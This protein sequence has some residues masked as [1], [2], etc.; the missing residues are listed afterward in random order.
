VRADDLVIPPARC[1][2]PPVVALPIRVAAVNG[3]ELVVEGVAGLLRR[4]PDRLEVCERIVIG[5]ELEVPVDVALYDT[6]GRTELVS[7]ALRTLI[8]QPFV[9]CVAI[10]TLDLSRPL[11]ADARGAGARGFISKA[12]SGDEVADALVRIADGEI[13]ELFHGSP[14]PATDVL[15][16]PGKND[17]LSERE[18]QVLVLCAQGLTNPEIAKSLYVG[19]ETVKSHLRNV[20]AKLGLKNRIEA[21][22]Y[23]L[24]AGGFG[25][26]P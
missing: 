8:K 11:I 6:Y 7:D 14:H 26:Y 24:S 9:G 20:Y 5:E 22:A 21:A 16:W 12:A 18:S 2:T 25:R 19:V 15:V 13:V 1:E 10:F 17:G 4:F 23:V 3:Y